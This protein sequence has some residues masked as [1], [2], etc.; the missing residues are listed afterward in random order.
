M[1]N[2]DVSSVAAEMGIDTAVSLKMFRNTAIRF[3]SQVMAMTNTLRA[4]D[5]GNRR[6]G[7][8]I[9]VFHEIT[10]D[11]LATHL[12]HLAEMY[13]FVPLEEFVQRL[14]THKSTVGTA[15]ITFDDGVDTVTEAAASLAA[16]HGWPMTFYLPTRYLD[17]GQPYWF[18]EL[19]LLLNRATGATLSFNNNV[20]SLKSSA[21]IQKTSKILRNYFKTLSTVDEVEDSLRR[22]RRHLFGSED[23]PAGL[24]T[25]NPISWDRVRKLARRDELSF[26]AH[27]INHLAV[28]R[29]T[30]ACLIKELEGSRSR[31]EEFTG[32]PVEDF[33]YPY[34]SPREVGNTAPDIVRKIFRSATTTSRGRC[35]QDVDM[36]LLPRVPID[37][38]D[39]EAVVALKVGSAR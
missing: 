22:I 16:H 6:R 8:V 25:P 12:N 13:T 38:Q 9:L 4:I 31:I 3:T 32:K 2:F 34:G 37:A 36:A 30:E 14:A 11:L 27:S 29:L 33:C 23:R 21:A 15:A 17:T 24:S 35:S 1:G 10:R 20:L 7:G 19:D 28:S 18:L 5:R 26:Q 39:A